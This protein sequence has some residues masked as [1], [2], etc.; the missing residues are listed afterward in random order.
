MGPE[1]PVDQLEAG[2]VLKGRAALPGAMNNLEDDRQ[3]QAFMG[4]RSS[5]ARLTGIWLSRSPLSSN[6][7]G[8]DAST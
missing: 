8:S 1:K 7:G 5:S 4:T 2:I 3:T 6:R